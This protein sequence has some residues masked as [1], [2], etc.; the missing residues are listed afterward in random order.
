MKNLIIA[1]G[2]LAIIAAAVGYNVWR[3]VSEP[4]VATPGPY[5]LGRQQLHAQLD[6]AK[7][8]EAQ[9]EQQDWNSITLLHGIIAAHQQRIDKLTGNT[10]ASEILAYD[11]DSITR[12]E[13]R[14]A[15]LEAK[16]RADWAQKTA[17]TTTPEALRP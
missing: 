13:A 2:V 16:Q 4:V 7:K 15:E 11:H 8:R 12:L 14:I 5:E 17:D 9:F 6:A 10:Q 1:I 3:A